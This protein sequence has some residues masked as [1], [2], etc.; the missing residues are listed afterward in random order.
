MEFKFSFVPTIDEGVRL[1]K[2]SFVK[3]DLKRNLRSYIFLFSMVLILGYCVLALVIQVPEVILIGFL[4]IA[5]LEV[6]FFLLPVFRIIL[7][8]SVESTTRKT[9]ESNKKAYFVERNWT[10]NDDGISVKT[11]ER[12]VYLSKSAIKS[13]SKNSDGFVFTDD[14]GQVRLLP[15]RVMGDMQE[16]FSSYISEKWSS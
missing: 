8:K 5:I 16:S 11:S 15:F 12:Y 4:C 7:I 1:N 9:L 14:I 3:N 10:I 6:L 13:V 2:E